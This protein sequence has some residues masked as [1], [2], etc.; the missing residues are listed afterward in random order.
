M[1]F[2]IFFLL[3]TSELV[4][5]LEE[6]L[7]ICW[8]CSMQLMGSS[9]FTV[10]WGDEFQ[11]LS[12][13]ASPKSSEELCKFSKNKT[14]Q[15]GTSYKDQ[16]QVQQRHLHAHSGSFPVHPFFWGIFNSLLR[17]LF[18]SSFFFA[19]PMA[20]GSSQAQDWT[21]ATAVT[22]ATAVTILGP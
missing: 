18:F 11:S 16:L 10:S 22:Q 15:E 9:S 7:S 1:I 19:T 8:G 21:H 5:L 4:L 2:K 17:K 13:D 14:C 12:V 6:D 3:F 20:C